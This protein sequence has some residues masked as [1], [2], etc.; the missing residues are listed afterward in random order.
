MNNYLI[1]IGWVGSI[2]FSICAVP[3]AYTCYKQKHANG[4]SGVFIWMW[5]WGEILTIIY[6]WPSKNMPLLFNYIFN[7]ACLLIIIYY[8]YNNRGNKTV[9]D[10]NYG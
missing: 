2:L 4:L 5:F 8:K 10:N 9:E 7:L 3:Q 1:Y 6:V